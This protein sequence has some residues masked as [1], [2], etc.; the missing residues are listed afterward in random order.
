MALRNAF[1]GL[2]VES[3]Q[4]T[5]IEKID[6]LAKIQFIGNVTTTKSVLGD[7][8]TFV[9]TGLTNTSG[10]D[11]QTITINKATGITTKEWS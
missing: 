2:A 1:E 11:T 4:D 3:K 8:T 7:V 10:I 9:K 5:I 6:K